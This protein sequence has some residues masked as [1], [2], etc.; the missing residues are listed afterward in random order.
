MRSFIVVAMVLLVAG[1]TALEAQQPVPNAVVKVPGRDTLRLTLT[2]ALSQAEPASEQVGIAQA[3]V[4][5]TKGAVMQ[6]RSALLPQVNLGPQYTYIFENPYQNLFPASDSLSNPFTSTN[7]WRIGGSVGM[8]LLNLSQ[9]AQLGASKTATRVAELQ[10][11]QQQAFTILNVASAYY[12]AALTARLVAIT[13]FTLAQAERTLK[14]VTLG[15]DVGT[16]SEF[17]QLR[18]RVARDNQIPVV[19]RARANRDITATRLKQLL[20][21]PLTTEIVLETPLDDAEHPGMLPANIDTMVRGA[22]TSA[23][24]RAVVRTAEQTVKQNEQLN[25]AA[26][27]LWIPTLQTTMN[28]NRAGFS[29]DFFPLDSEF[30]NDWNLITVLNWP[31]FTSGRILGTK[32]QTAANL[33]AARL[34]AKLTGEQAALDNETINARLRE[35]QDNALATAS[36]VEQATRANEIAELRYKEGLSTQTELQDVRLQLEQA[37]ANQAQAARDLQVARLRLT[38]LPYLPLGTA[39]A[40]ALTTSTV[41]STGAAVQNFN[42]VVT[43]TGR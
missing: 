4:R 32:K 42:S 41:T 27:R 19:T 2:Q 12:D 21:I 38:L 40:T 25:Q 37:R 35:A 33:D 36:V 20:D 13:E 15:R 14:D 8:S 5:R 34:Q 43:S 39:D 26:G 1:G 24:A 10:L 31:I 3:G 9:W 30:G 28:Y 29:A 23:A 7:Q 6:T 16:Q 18:S 22:D 17:E 11:T